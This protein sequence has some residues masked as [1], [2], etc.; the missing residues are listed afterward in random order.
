[1][2][3]LLEVAR[4]HLRAYGPATP[5]VFAGWWEMHQITA[6]EAYCAL[7][8]EIVPVDVEGWPAF[9][10]RDTVEGMQAAAQQGVVRL[11]PLF[12]ACL[13]GIGRRDDIA[14]LVAPRHYSR[15]FRVAGWVSAVVL[16][17]GRVV[18]TWQSKARRSA[19]MVSVQMFEQPDAAVQ[20]GIA[21]EAERLGSF[22][23][24]PV[25]LHVGVD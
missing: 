19:T 16:V 5:P 18:G 6:R 1:R 8:D 17:D 21:Q 7:G 24:T 13:M 3:A 22:L 25:L 10:L 2:E 12:D 20:E 15:V 14:P 4:R 11:L 9:A 23:G